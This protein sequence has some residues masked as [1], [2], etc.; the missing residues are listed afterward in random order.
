MAGF[1][2]NLPDVPKRLFQ[3]EAD[4]LRDRIARA[5][6]LATGEL[7]LNIKAKGDADILGAGN[8][9]RRWTDAFTVQAKP[10][11]AE[12]SDK[13][14]ISIFFNSTIPFAHIHEFGGTIKAK[15]TL[16]GPPLLWIP[17]KG[18]VPR[19]KGTGANAGLMTAQEFGASQSPLFRVNRKG[20]APLL[21]DIKSRRPRYFGIASV[22]LPPRFHIRDIS[23]REAGKFQQLFTAAVKATQVNA[24]R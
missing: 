8:F 19:S 4:R 6:Q 24:T 5:I 14:L 22:T 15:G 20:K 7:M 21:L 1:H 12:S 16:F 17:L 18:A 2:F 9:T 13:Y 23:A 10:P 3:T 11:I